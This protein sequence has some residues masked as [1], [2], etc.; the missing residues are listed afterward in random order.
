[1]TQKNNALL[2]PFNTPHEA[3]PFDRIKTE[4]F[5]PAIAEAITLHQAEIDAIVAQD[6]APTFANTIEAME[7]SGSKLGRITSIFF[8]LLSANGDDEMIAASERISPLLTEH[9]NNI[10]LNEAL[11]K[12]V[13]TVYEQRDTLPL[14]AEE[15]RLLEETYNGMARSGANL[16]GEAREKYR[17][18][19]SELSR[20]C[21]KFE[22]NLLKA[23]N[24]FEMIL[25]DSADVAG[26]PQ[27]ALDAAA[28]RAKEKGHEGAY[29][30]DLS[31][32][33]MSA[34]LKYAERRDLR[35][36]IYT[37]YNTR[38]VSGE[39]DN[40]D[41]VAR[42]A[43]LRYETARLLGYENFAEYVLEHRMAQN[44]TR[45]Y[46]L[47]NQLL[48]AYKPVAVEEVKQLQAFAEKVEGH[49]VE[50]M[51]WDYSYYSTRQKDALY[52]LNDEMLK[53]YFELEQVKKGVF[54]LATRLY[55]L[56]FKKTTD[57][58]VYHKEVETF[59]VY[60]AD[61]SYLGLLYTD[62]YPRSTKQGGAWMTSFK[63]QWIDADG[64]NSRPHISLV[65][66]FTRPTESAPALLTYDEVETFLHEFGH[67]LHGLMANS[68]YES[69]SG[70][71]VYRDFVELPSQLM[72]NWLPEQDF[73]ATFA[74]HYVTGE[75]LPD[76]LVTKIRNAQRYHA[77]YY[78]VRQL[79]YGILDMAWHTSEGKVDDIAAF[80]QQAIA[81]TQLLPALD[82][83]L[84]SCQ[85]S[86]IFGGGYAAGYYGYKWAEV[87]DADAF[88]LFKE[89]G[90]FD[91][92]TATSFRKNILEK[93]DTE[94]PMSLYI[95]FRGREPRI[96]ALMERD[97]IR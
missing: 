56:T 97:G 35:K 80:E 79:T 72:E 54:G 30:F 14:S 78:C 64:T 19:S 43:E 45:V 20:L 68:K 13:K 59:E 51:P 84:F 39:Y 95:R 96:D 27:S 37:A 17:E 40:R 25:T 76:S 29:L 92:E 81:S 63:D 16:E 36:K 71:N 6:E 2:S 87:L 90:I 21:L 28:M 48:H 77:A 1:M 33:S 83:A 9:S 62:F 93:G 24:A 18:L 58:P 53:P 32:P 23:T 11:F 60:D 91:K 5:E 88:S 74:R 57:I 7:L 61:S 4:D 46:D 89:K 70:T 75:I 69:L 44:S 73:L 8:N 66:N 3:A 31:Y 12:R 26:L 15:K 42:I 67:A 10:N 86:H 22:S 50:L 94:D 52:E 82:G 65:M 55:G 85:F 47:L 49:P 38:C 34:F 41:I